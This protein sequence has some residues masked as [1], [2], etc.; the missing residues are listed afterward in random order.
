[1]SS[2]INN[3]I[4]RFQSFEFDPQLP[5]YKDILVDQKEI[6]NIL[7]LPNQFFYIADLNE[8]VNIY[9]H[10]NVEH[11]LGYTPEDFHSF[12]LLHSI[13][14]PED[15]AFFLEYTIK[16]IEYT[17][18]PELAVKDKSHWIFGLT[19]RLRNR[20]SHY[21]WVER[22]TNCFK[23]DKLNN[24]VYVLCLYSDVTHLKKNNLIDY[25]WNADEEVPFDIND[26]VK[27]HLAPAFSKREIEIIQLIAQG[28]TA[29]KIAEQLFISLDTAITHRKNILHKAN[30]T[31]CAQLVKF[32][33]EHGIIS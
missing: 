7:V 22:H 23:F 11:V 16:V 28:L 24:L 30:A 29:R 9:V 4:Q 26:L 13:L 12:N 32:A 5:K 6:N 15:E 20:S 21:I 1:M 31:N 27:K 25:Y 33:I 17:R 8:L 18:I 14:H 2:S 3:Y 10:P 19:F